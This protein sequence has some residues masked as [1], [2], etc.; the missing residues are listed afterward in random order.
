MMTEINGKKISPLGLGT[1]KM[2]GAG[3]PETADDRRNIAALKY[4]IENGITLIDTAEMYGDGHSEEIVG[5]AIADFPREDLFIVTKVWNDHLRHDD[6]IKSAKKS[7]MR[8]D[9]GYID[10]YLIHWPSPTIPIGETISAMEELVDQGIIRN[11][12]VS[13]FN[14][15][16]LQ[17]A[18]DSTKKYDIVV[19]QL[20]YNIS[21]R[22]VER[23][24]LDFCRKNSV[25]IVAYSPLNQGHLKISKNVE[26]IAEKVG[27]SPVQVI[28]RYLMR[29]S[30]P[31]PKS[32]S[33]DHI[34][35]FIGAMKEDLPEEYAREI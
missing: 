23:D 8:L 17:D 18:I 15:Q 29:N 13:N 22:S 30:I 28:L 25:K 24:I 12:G 2:G 10:L 33:P 21:N 34:K 9:A 14:N 27:I 4:G 35:E 16:L 7:L 6:L 32:S 11:I 31:I 1:W 20:E 3:R 19:N 26:R 5:K